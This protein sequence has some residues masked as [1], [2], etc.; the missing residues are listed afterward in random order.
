MTKFTP[1]YELAGR[2][3]TSRRFT[4]RMATAVLIRTLHHP[5]AQFI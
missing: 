2:W 5:I 1:C 3:S 4:S